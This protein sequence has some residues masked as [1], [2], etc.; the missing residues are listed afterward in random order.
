[1]VD[2]TLLIYA[3]LILVILFA[4]IGAYYLLYTS[5]IN[6]YK[7]LIIAVTKEYEKSTELYA[8]LYSEYLQ[9]LK[10]YLNISKEY[11]VLPQSLPSPPPISVPNLP[12]S[13]SVSLPSQIPLPVPSSWPTLPTT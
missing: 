2:T 3:G 11:N 1:M 13:I 5:M 12:F 4:T 8:K 9:L 7:E 6:A 10:E